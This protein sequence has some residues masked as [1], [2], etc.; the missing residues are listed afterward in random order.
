MD[1]LENG[2]ELEDHGNNE[3]ILPPRTLDDPIDDENV[4]DGIVSDPNRVLA[5]VKLA[6][7]VREVLFSLVN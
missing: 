3:R 1:T 5:D 7:T 4:E 2:D 6:M